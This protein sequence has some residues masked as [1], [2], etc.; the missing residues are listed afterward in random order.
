MQ[1][2]TT[3]TQILNF[4]NGWKQSVNLLIDKSKSKTFGFHTKVVQPNVPSPP[5]APLPPQQQQP[6]SFSDGSIT[7][8]ITTTD[9]PA[10]VEKI[11]TIP[12]SR[13]DS[14][15]L[16]LHLVSSA[17]TARHNAA[18]T[19]APNLDSRGGVKDIHSAI[20]ISKFSQLTV[21]VGKPTFTGQLQLC[22]ALLAT[23]DT[24]AFLFLCNNAN[25]AAALQ[26]IV[27]RG[28]KGKQITLVVRALHAMV[29]LGGFKREFLNNKTL[30]LLINLATGTVHP[31]SQYGGGGGGGESHPDVKEAAVKL[32]ALYPDEVMK[33]AQVEEDNLNRSNEVAQQQ[34]KKEEEAPESVEPSRDEGVESKEEKELAA[35]LLSEENEAPAVE[36]AAVDT[37]K[38]VFS[39]DAAVALA[40][41]E[42]PKELSL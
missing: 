35:A 33:A 21:A 31:R 25:V 14:E 26:S 39:I 4:F 40:T 23:T 29:H 2:K 22:D 27:S 3:R 7:L 32:L 9:V 8:P 24:T 15:R 41:G 28:M 1:V 19:L 18:A 6:Q 37:F 30:Q 17:T 36:I 20:N 11:E 34:Q 42:M 10:P 5:S 12:T 38:Q 13:I 16:A